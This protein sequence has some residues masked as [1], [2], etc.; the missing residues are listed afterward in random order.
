MLRFLL[1]S[2]L[3]ILRLLIVIAINFVLFLMIPLTHSLSEKIKDKDNISLREPRIIAEYIK[4]PPKEE[5]REYKPRIRQIKASASNQF[6]KEPISLK[7][8]PDLAVEQGST[9]GV[10][11]SSGELEAVVFEEGEVDQDAQ[12]VNR[13]PI[14]YPQRARELGIEGDLVLVLL[15]DIDGKVNSVE[16]ISSPDQ[17]ISRKATEIIL[18][19][20]KF[21]PAR[22]Q[23]IPVKQ[24]VKQKIS[25]RLDS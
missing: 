1:K 5:K 18:S 8:I 2:S 22:N 12:P 3:F 11:M 9:D 23:G 14:P 21:K 13:T 16:V 15:I 24:R 6:S 20:W 17:I 25:F 7:F 19:S 10:A 4:P